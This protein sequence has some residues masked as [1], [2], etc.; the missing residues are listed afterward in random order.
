MTKQERKGRQGPKA[1]TKQT[2]GD[3]RVLFL[4]PMKLS[5]NTVMHITKE[6]VDP[7]SASNHLLEFT[8]PGYDMSRFS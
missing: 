6:G 2:V 8:V 5:G 1:L 4:E 7:S 3:A